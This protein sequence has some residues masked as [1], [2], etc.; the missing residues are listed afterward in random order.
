MLVENAVDFNSYSAADSDGAVL[1][2]MLGMS[3]PR[4]GYSGLI[5]VRLDLRLLI[6]FARGTP[7]GSLVLAGKVDSRGCEALLDELFA[8]PN[9]HFL[10]ELPPASVPEFVAGLDVGLLPYQLNRET[11]HISPL[12]LYEY[13]A[14]AK[15]VISTPI[16]AARRHSGLVRL[17]QTASEFRTAG[18]ELIANDNEILRDCRRQFAAANTWEDRISQIKAELLPLLRNRRPGACAS[19]AEC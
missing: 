11:E 16:P 19:P 9:V 10:G 2:T 6:E 1:V 8:L 5:G 13:L 17:A 3:R 7:D 15:P 12:K 4:Y 18:Q 14:A